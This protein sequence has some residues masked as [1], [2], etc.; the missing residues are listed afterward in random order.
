MFELSSGAPFTLSAETSSYVA[1]LIAYTFAI[2]V[3]RSIAALEPIR[4]KTR[5]AGFIASSSEHI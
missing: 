5:Q 3:S 1:F 2:W 4:P